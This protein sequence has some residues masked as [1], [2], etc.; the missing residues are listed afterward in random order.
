MIARREREDDLTYRLAPTDTFRT[1]MIYA[2]ALTLLIFLFMS[3]IIKYQMI[4]N[5][6]IYQAI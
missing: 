3:H 5:K 4:L 1:G 2:E 6:L